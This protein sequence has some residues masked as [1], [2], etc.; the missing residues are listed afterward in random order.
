MF[1][2]SLEQVAILGVRYSLANSTGL[3]DTTI[4]VTDVCNDNNILSFA[5]GPINC[6]SVNPRLR[7]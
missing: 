3:L 7:V 6:G 2:L 5:S 1:A 4:A